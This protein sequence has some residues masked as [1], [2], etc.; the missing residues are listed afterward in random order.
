M[1]EIARACLA[2]VLSCGLAYGGWSE[3]APHADPYFDTL[4][5]V[6]RENKAPVAA[7][8]LALPEIPPSKAGVAGNLYMQPDAAGALEQLFAAAE[9]EQ[10]YRL[11]GVSGY[12]S[13]GIQSAIY[14]RRVEESGDYAKKY[15]APGGYSEHQT[16]LAMDITGASVRD[17]GLTSKF[18]E[19]EEG[20]WVALNAHRFGFIIRYQL[21]W[22]KITGYNY[23]PWHLRYVGLEHA[24]RLYELNIPL[25]EYLALLQRERAN[26]VYAALG[27][28]PPF[29]PA[30]TPAPEPMP[31]PAAEPAPAR[32]AAPL[33]TLSPQAIPTQQPGP[34]PFGTPVPI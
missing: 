8:A 30:P 10:G 27:L 19:T 9:A 11:Y 26:D 12:R 33:M 24:A 18:G 13:A 34:N 22:E 16:G 1:V 7:P 23:E 4:I 20:L 32:T 2:L 3:I 6:N 21:G 14:E 17:Q 15:V 31:E 25:E 28:K 29:A 5:L